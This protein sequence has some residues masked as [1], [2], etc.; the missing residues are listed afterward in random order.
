MFKKHKIY[1]DANFSVNQYRGM[2]KYINSFTEILKTEGMVIEGLLKSN[3]HLKGEYFSFGFSNYIL[4]EQF[5]LRRFRNNNDGLFF[6]PYNTAPLFLR[7]SKYNVLILHDLIFLQKGETTSFKQKI[8][9]FYRSFI[10]PRIVKRFDYIITVSEYSKSIIVDKLHVK[11]EKITVIPNCVDLFESNPLP[12]K[13]RDKNVFFHI[14]GEPGYK[15]SLSLLY[16]FSLLPTEIQNTHLLKILGIRDPLTLTVYKKIA[17]DLKITEQVIFL[18]YQTDEQ[19]ESLYREAK[20]FLFPSLE[21]GFGIPLIEAMKFG[22]PIIA[23]NR[24]CIPE[25]AGKAALYYDPSDSNAL[26]NT[27]MTLLMDEQQIELLI[28]EGYE[29]VKKFSFSTFRNKVVEWYENFSRN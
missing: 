13:V 25:I 8:G 16:A 15:N 11:P 28:E 29:Q 10:V 9:K 22:C 1:Y 14:G 21:E 4:W 20:M 19:V 6:F 3:I 12:R 17:A 18:P 26:A 7:K 24:S 27:I 5:S 23:S 2:G